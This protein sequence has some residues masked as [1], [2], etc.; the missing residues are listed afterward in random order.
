VTEDLGQLITDP[1]SL[2]TGGFLKDS[3]I[4]QAHRMFRDIL[5][6]GILENPKAA[7]WVASHEDIAAMPKYAQAEWLKMEDLDKVAPGLSRTVER[8]IEK[9][10]EKTG[11]HMPQPLPAIDKSLVQQFFGKEG[12][13]VAQSSNA[14]KLFELLTAVHKTART[15]LN[16]TTH[17]ANLI[18]NFAMLSMAGMNPFSKQALNDGR[19]FTKA[20]G[21]LAK[22]AHRGKAEAKAGKA[23]TVFDS[24]ESLMNKETLTKLFGKDNIIK[25]VNGENINLAEFFS[26][27]LVKGMIEAS[28]F[29]N[30]EGFAHLK[31]LLESLDRAEAQGFGTNALKVVGQTITSAGEARGVKQTLEGMSSAYLAEDMIPKMMYCAK[32]LR[33]GWGRDAIIR[34]VGRRLPQYRTV[35]DIPAASRKVLLPWI[36]FPAEMTRIMKNNLMDAP[37][38]TSMWMQAPEIL[39]ASTYAAG[40]GPNFEEHEKAI[41]AAPSWAMRYQTAMVKGEKAPEALMTMGG[42]TT[43]GMVGGALG[44]AKGAAIGAGVGAAAGLA[45]G[46]A[47]DTPE[48]RMLGYRAWVADFLPQSAIFPGSTHPRAAHTANPFSEDVPGGEWLRAV[49]DM[50][51]VEPFAVLMPLI[52]TYQGRG[53][54]G[55]EIPSVG[56]GVVSKM[57]MALMGFL[58]PPMM[59]KYGMKIEGPQLNP[60]PMSQVHENNGGRMTLPKNIT[61]TFGGLASAGI[62]FMGGKYGMGLKGAAL[63]APTALAGVMGAT[64]GKEVNVRRLMTD[65]GIMGDPVTHKKG[66]WTLDAVANNFFGT[67]KSWPADAP[68]KIVEDGRKRR[69]FSEIRG[70]IVRDIT[71]SMLTK[72]S[73]EAKYHFSRLY[74]NHLSEWGNAEVAFEKTLE[75]IEAIN[76]SWSKTPQYR[77]MSKEWVESRIAALRAS[78]EELTKIERQELAELKA[79]NQK[80]QMDAARNLKITK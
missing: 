40:L 70:Q 57:A 32:L 34:E 76:N 72:R 53:S 33:E 71:D 37:I 44:G 26:D 50:S 7:Q 43:G 77:G 20:F 74:E 6:D 19:T 65:L 21:S 62:T 48:D 59:Q 1:K 23:G 47:Q 29:E 52:D 61:A 67:A 30:I 16:P 22:M 63:A 5:M 56:G 73:S 78:K 25:G 36:T 39:R 4:F 69:H 38:S 42:A 11:G 9:G 45:M 60:I 14:M 51:P 3:M 79:L 35:G 46:K 2:T 13:A 80:Q 68:R 28:A 15:S 41:D 10:F 24:V 8:M 27:D 12:S 66:N 54:F 64:A 18:G 55:E 49:T 31:K 17:Q 58:S 75:S